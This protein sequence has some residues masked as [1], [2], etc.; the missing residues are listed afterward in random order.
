M[1]WTGNKKVNVE[2]VNDNNKK[3]FREITLLRIKLDNV[4]YVSR[5]GLASCFQNIGPT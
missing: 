5:T 3:R 1:T 4:T 2:R